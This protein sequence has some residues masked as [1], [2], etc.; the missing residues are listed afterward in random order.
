MRY[1]SVFALT[2]AS[3][4]TVMSGAATAQYNDYP[5]GYSDY[6]GDSQ[7]LVSS[8]YQRF[9]GRPP[10]PGSATWVQQLQDG[11]APDAVLAGILASDEYYRRSGGSP[12]GFVRKLF[13]DLTSRRPGPREADYWT[14]R[15]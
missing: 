13:R 14:R 1:F 11:S 4:F 6:A 5:Y 8:W 12:E 10:D 7:A 15:A 9:L 3:M 2:A